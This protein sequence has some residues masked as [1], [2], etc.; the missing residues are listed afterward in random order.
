MGVRE[1]VRSCTPNERG[2]R[3]ASGARYYGMN[4][5][6]ET[7]LAARPSFMPG[8]RGAALPTKRESVGHCELDS[9]GEVNDLRSYRTALPRNG[10]FS[11]A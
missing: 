1:L 3:V 10:V 4:G 8:T 9:E 11:V 7:P 2:A 6:D 5:K